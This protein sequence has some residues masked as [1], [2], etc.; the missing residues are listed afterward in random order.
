MPTRARFLLAT[1]LAVAGAAIPAPAMAASTYY[2]GPA[3]SGTEC[4][5]AAPCSLSGAVTKAA[6]GDAVVLLPGTYSLA[7]SLQITHSISFGGESET[8]TTIQTVGTAGI[9]VNETANA[10]LHDFRFDTTES[11]ELKSGTAERVFVDYR[12]TSLGRSACSLDPGT[13]LLDSVCWAHAGSPSAGAIFTE[14]A[15]AGTN[16]VTL[17]NVT[18]IAADTEGV[19]IFGEVESPGTSFTIAATNV[20]TRGGGHDVFIENGGGATSHASVALKNSNFATVKEQGSNATVTT[21]G[22]NGNQTA[23][24]TFVEAA[25][26]NFAET[27]G[28]PTVDAG[29][30]EAANGTTALAG[31]ARVLPGVCNGTPLTDIGAY[32]LVLT[33][34]PPVTPLPISGKRPP[35]NKITL[36]KLKVNPKKGTATLA[37]SVPDAGTLVLTGKGIKKVT[38]HLNSAAKL[39]LPIAP[40]GKAKRQLARTGAAKFKLKLSFVPTGGAAGTATKSVKLSKRSG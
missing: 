1:V 9:E 35:S 8:N 25:G 27:A 26:G 4:S 33:G 37:V 36:G 29:V 14:S 10:R 19:G 21:P 38:R 30:T 3:G 5:Q 7:T 12:G 22:T 24:P 16:Q 15:S 6:N 20:I 11:L 18:A 28:S 17:R 23:A 32:E 13:T 39:K 40:V 2:A 31:E 34:C